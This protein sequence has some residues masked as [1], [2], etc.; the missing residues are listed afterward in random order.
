MSSI[1]KYYSVYIV[2]QGKYS[3]PPGDLSFVMF[4]LVFPT[5]VILNY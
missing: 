1:L 3:V 5:W 2:Q 4:A